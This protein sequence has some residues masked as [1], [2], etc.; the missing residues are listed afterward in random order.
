MEV[1]NALFSTS[2][3]S[4]GQTTQKLLLYSF[5]SKNNDRDTRDLLVN[6]EIPIITHMQAA[7]PE[8]SQ[9]S[10]ITYNEVLDNGVKTFSKKLYYLRNESDDAV[11]GADSLN[12]RF[13]VELNVD[14]DDETN[15]N[16]V[17]R[18][19]LARVNSFGLFIK[20]LK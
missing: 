7:T 14:Y 11:V 1:N 15:A 3:S 18:G 5:E 19:F 16:A 6:E 20:K 9:W 17:N 10:T 13:M 12:V 4:G 8:D 2:F